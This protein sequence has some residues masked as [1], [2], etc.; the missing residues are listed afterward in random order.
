MNDDNDYEVL[1]FFVENVIKPPG[2]WLL[3]Q[4]GVRRPHEHETAPLF[5]GIAFWAFVVFLVCALVL[6][7]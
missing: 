2:R 5:T 7:W 4:F 6:R 3:E 1:K